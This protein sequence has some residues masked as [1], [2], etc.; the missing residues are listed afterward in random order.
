MENS[1]FN[2]TIIIFIDNIEKELI[3]EIERPISFEGKSFSSP[4]SLDKISFYL[5][6]MSD[7]FVFCHR[8]LYL[9]R[10]SALNRHQGFLDPFQIWRVY[11]VIWRKSRAVKS[12]WLLGEGCCS[13]FYH[14]N[15]CDNIINF[16][17]LF[18]AQCLFT[19][20]FMLPVL[21]HILARLLYCNSYPLFLLYVVCLM[22]SVYV[23]YLCLWLIS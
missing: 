22:I 20:Y 19:V 16:Y 4:L 13:R 18:Y 15:T 7:I 8:H 23:K 3:L 14:R 11:F 1:Y 12:W 2:R 21:G 17:C 9:I 10:I 6:K 5:F